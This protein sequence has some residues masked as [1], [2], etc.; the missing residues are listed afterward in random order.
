[1]GEVNMKRITSFEVNH[2]K[3][4][5]GIYVSRLDFVGEHCITTFDLRFTRPNFEPVMGTGAIHALE[6]LGATFLR[7]HNDFKEKIIYFGPMGCR[8]GFY[9]LMSGEYKSSDIVSLIKEMIN[10]IIHFKGDIPGASPKECG[11]YIDMD[12]NMAIY[13]SK[14]FENEVLNNLSENNLNY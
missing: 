10:F 3:L 7:N 12:L 5:P 14:K 6:H 13:Y 9:L 8:T 4:V 2:L 1:M 11:N